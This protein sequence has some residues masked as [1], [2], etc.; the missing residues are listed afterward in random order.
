MNVFWSWQSDF[1]PKANRFFIRDA[2]S[3]SIDMLGDEL[4][5]EEA[6]RPRIDHDTKDAAGIA[7]IVHTIFEKISNA[8]AF[9]ADVTPIART[10]EGKAVPNPN[11]LVELG[12]A[13]RS[14]GPDHIITIL[15]AA[16]GY[17]PDDLPFDLRQ[18][19][20]LTYT[21]PETATPAEKATQKKTLASALKSALAT[22]LRNFLKSALLVG[23][24]TGV[25]ADPI[26]RSIWNNSGSEIRFKDGTTVNFPPRPRIYM[27][28]VPAY[29]GKEVPKARGLKARW[30]L[31]M[32][33]SGARWNHRKETL[34][35]YALCH[36]PRAS[37][38]APTAIVYYH[39]ESG[40]LWLQASAPT[41]NAAEGL[42]VI[43]YDKIVKLWSLFLRDAHRAL[44]RLGSARERRVEVGA[45]GM[46]S[47]RWP[48]SAPTGE[49][50]ARDDSFHVSM[51]SHAWGAEEQLKILITATN[52]LFVSFGFR[53]E[54]EQNLLNLLFSVDDHRDPNREPM[55]DA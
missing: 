55:Q 35:G 28:V 21:L 39:Y 48:G 18:R 36:L 38:D 22:N 26:D 6:P 1:A 15:N 30:I 10:D 47:I 12:W 43:D 29:W 42:P 8:A 49:R 17:G 33:Y 13:M 45:A 24:G 3:L 40:E 53:E 52:R 16:S 11:V 9:V 4:T 27:R 37:R 25:S 46:Q 23:G 41:R 2:L 54:S 14:L 20:V 34:D 32:S 50:G 19:R 44:S 5:L 31:P 7:D 51:I